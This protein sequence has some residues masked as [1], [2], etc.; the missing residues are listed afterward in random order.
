MRHK[1]KKEEHERS[2]DNILEQ[3]GAVGEPTSEII[4]M[5]RQMLDLQNRYEETKKAASQ[6]YDQMEKI[7]MQLYD[8]MKDIGIDQFRTSEFGLISCANTLYGKI[9]DIEKASEWLK[10]NGLF[11]QILKYTPQ[12]GRVNELLK[13]CIEDGKPIPP[14]FD[15]SLMKSIGHRSA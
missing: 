7:E 11:E 9:V 6:L 4:D 12:R 10:E 14:G 15:Y 5:T 1:H 8:K 2:G 3:Q 13:K